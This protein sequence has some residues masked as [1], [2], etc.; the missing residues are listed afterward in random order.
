MTRCPP[1]SAGRHVWPTDDSV[2][3]NG[4]SDDLLRVGVTASLPATRVCLGLTPCPTRGP[5]ANSSPSGVHLPAQRRRVAAGGGSPVPGGVAAEPLGGRRSEPGAAD[6]ATH[7]SVPLARSGTRPRTRRQARSRYAASASRR[8][9]GWA[10]ASRLRAPSPVSLFTSTA[11]SSAAS[12]RMTRP[13]PKHPRT[14]AHR[15]R[16]V[17]SNAIVSLPM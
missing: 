17:N 9:F 4:V 2:V 11:A 12:A 15:R 16:K 8:S 14:E 5:A 7:G 10:A 1:P 3:L 6:R 13:C